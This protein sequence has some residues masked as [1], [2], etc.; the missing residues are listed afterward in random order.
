MKQIEK[1]QELANKLNAMDLSNRARQMVNDT[2]MEC[3]D[4]IFGN[5]ETAEDVE[6]VVND[7]LNEE[8]TEEAEA[9]L[10]NEAIAMNVIAEYMDGDLREEL[11]NALA[12]CTD[13]E[14][15]A[16]YLRKH[17]EKYGEDFEIN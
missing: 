12:P 16:A 14:F 3:L 15:L 2:G 7:L 6:Q 17:K 11:H 8:Y 5:C 9:M 4:M 1:N 13:I 10:S